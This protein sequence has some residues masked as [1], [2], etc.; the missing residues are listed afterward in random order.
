[1]YGSKNQYA[2]ID[3]E[4]L[5][6]AQSTLYVQKVC[7]TFLYYAIAIYQTMLVDLNNIATEQDHTTTITM[8]DIVWL[9]NYT[10][11]HP[12]AAL[13]YRDSDMIL[14][15]AR[16]LSYLC[17]ER[18]HS[19]AGGHFPSPINLSKMAT[20]FPH[21]HQQRI[22]PHPVPANK[23]CHVLSNRSRNRHHFPQCKG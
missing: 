3:T 5:V 14:H 8:G 6:D 17:E 10:A 23:D 1:M 21:Y 18:A 2:D 15:V 9:L 13:H 20:N 16:N 22:H 7:E 4:E 19:R 11:N 12:D